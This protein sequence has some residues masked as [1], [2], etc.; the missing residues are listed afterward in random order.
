VAEFSLR[1]LMEKMN[2]ILIKNRALLSALTSSGHSPLSLDIHPLDDVSMSP[3]FQEQVVLKETHCFAPEVEMAPICFTYANFN[4]IA[5][6]HTSATI[7]EPA[8]IALETQISYPFSGK[9]FE[10]E[11]LIETVSN[12]FPTPM[13]AAKQIKQLARLRALEEQTSYLQALVRSDARLKVS[14]KDISEAKSFK[15]Q[16]IESMNLKR[17]NDTDDQTRLPFREQIICAE[18]HTTAI[19][20]ADE[21]E[22]SFTLAAQVK[23]VCVQQQDEFQ[24]STNS[25]IRAN[26]VDAQSDNEVDLFD[27]S[28]I[29]V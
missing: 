14:V 17:P 16:V 22:P 21:I 1:E 2:S 15:M 6:S 4:D 25:F 5:E 3:N 10:K 20:P 26:C 18:N 8:M 23:A 24:V 9:M 28:A 7:S 12:I 13:L 11:G 27:L 29:T 19:K